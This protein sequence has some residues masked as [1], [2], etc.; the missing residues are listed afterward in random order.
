MA[1]TNCDE[2][3]NIIS[4]GIITWDND[5]A[6]EIARLSS[7]KKDMLMRSKKITWEEWVDEL[8]WLSI[9]ELEL[10]ASS[11]DIELRAIVQAKILTEDVRVADAYRELASQIKK[12]WWTI[13]S[14]VDLLEKLRNAPVTDLEEIAKQW[15]WEYAKEPVKAIK[16][17][18]EAIASTISANYSIRQYSDFTS[19]WLM[20]LKKELREWKI[21]QKEFDKW[22]TSLHKEA[23]EQI[24]K[25]ENPKNFAKLDS[26]WNFIKKVYWDE[27]LK[28]WEAWTQF[29]MARELLAD[30]AIDDSILEAFA[31]LWWKNLA[32][33]LT[34]DWI[35]KCWKDDLAVLLAKAY[36]NTKQLYTDWVLREVYRQKLVELAGWTK[37]T[38]ENI[39]KA[40]SILNTIQFAEQWATFSHIVL[41]DN[42][43]RSAQRLW[44]KIEDWTKFVYWIKKFCK[45]LSEKPE[46]LDKPIVINWVEMSAL[47]LVQVIYD[48][49]WDENILK[50]I[51]LWFFPD[52]AILSVATSRLL[53]G[54]KEAAEKILKLFSKAKQVAKV[55]STRDVAMKTICGTEVKENAPIGFFD[56]KTSL[57]N[58]DKL[59]RTRADFMDKLA[60]K[61][62]MK[63]PGGWVSV[64]QTTDNVERLEKSLADY[65]W[66]YIVVRDAQWRD[67]DVLSKAIDNVNKDLADDEKITLLFP[68]WWITS[69]FVME[70]WQLYFKTLDDDIFDSVSW[71]ISIQTLMESRPTREILATAYE[72][73]TWKNWDKL[74]YQA[75]YTRWWQSIDG[76]TLSDQQLE[77]FA[78]AKVWDDWELREWVI[79]L[80]H[81]TA[82][83]YFTKFDSGKASVE[84][85]WWA[86]FYST[87]NKLDARSNYEW[88]WPVLEWKIS[89]RADIL[90]WEWMSRNEAEII[91]R[92]ELEKEPAMLTVY[93]KMEN[94]A[95]VGKTI[96]FD[97]LDEDITYLQ[98]IIL[99]SARMEYPLTNRD[100]K[101]IMQIVYEA[102]DEWWI[103]IEVF[104]KRLGIVLWDLTDDEGNLAVNDVARLILKDLWYDWIIDPTVASKFKWMWLWD[105]TVHYIAFD[106]N[107]YKFIDNKLPTDNLDMRYQKSLRLYSTQTDIS[108][109]DAM[110][111]QMFTK[112]RT[113]KQIADWYWLDVRLVEWN[114][115]E[116]IKAYWAYW[117]WLIYF[118]DLVKES[119]A[120]HELF[121]AV[122][123][124]AWKEQ[125]D[126]ILSDAVKLFW[127]DRIEAEEKLADAFA[128]WFKTWKFSYWDTSKRW[129]K[130]L[131]KKVEQFFKT[132]AEWLWLLDNHRNEVKQMFDD[133]VNMRYLPDAWKDINATEA[134]IKYNDELNQAASKYFWEILWISAP[135]V[136]TPEYIDSVQQILSDMLWIDLKAFSEI[137]NKSALWKKINQQFSL[138]KITTGKYDKQLIDI[139]EVKNEIANYTEDE[140]EENIKND[141]WDLMITG[142]IKWNDNI[143]HIREA[144]LDYKTAPTAV[145]SLTAKWKIVSLANWWTAQT[146]TMQ[147]I[148]DMFTNWTF[149][150]KYK[151]MFFPNQT[152]TDKDL[153]KFANAIN[154]DIFDTLSIMFA[155]N[156]VSAWYSLPLINIKE[157]VYDYLHW[158]LNLN[159]K[160]VSSFLYKNWIPFTQDWLRWIVETLMPNE[161]KFNYEDS[162]FKW[163]FNQLEKWKVSAVVEVDNI[164]LWDSYSALAS[165]EWARAW[166]T[167]TNHEKDILTSILDKYNTAVTEWIKDWTLTFQKAQQL[168]QEA[169]YALDMF[170]QDFLLPRYW[171]FLT[172]TERQWLMWMK[173]SLPIWV[174]W[175]NIDKV[176]EELTSI[177]TNLIDKYD[178]ILNWAVKNNE[179]NMA[180]VKWMEWE[181]DDMKKRIDARRQQLIENWWIIKEVGWTYVVYDVKQALYD[182]INNLPDN[183][184]WLEWLKA[185][186][187]DWIESMSNK[188]AYAVLRYLEAAKWLNTTVNYATSIMYRLNP[189]LAKCNFFENYKAVNWIPRI[190]EWNI[191]NSNKFL[192]QFDNVSSFDNVAKKTIFSK[193]V[194]KFKAQGYLTSN[195]LSKIV[196]DWVDEVHSTIKL[197]WLNPEDTQKAIDNMKLVY[198]KAFTPYTYVRDI[199]K[200]WKL[201][202]WRTT[203][204]NVKARVEWVMKQQYEQAIDDLKAVWI[205]D[206]DNVQNSIYIQLNN[207]DRISLADAGKMNIDSWKKDIFNDE[208]VFVAWADEL[209]TFEWSPDNTNLLE[210]QKEY[211]NWIISQYDS[212]L[213]SL[214]SQTQFISDSE[215]KLHTAF[216]NDVRQT[217]RWY[218]LT[219]KIVDALD[220]VGWLNEEAARWI[221][222]YLIWWK[223]NMAFG[224]W[225][226]N[227]I[228]DRNKLVKEA[229]RNY[230]YMDISK[231]NKVVPNSKAEDLAL[232]LAKYFKSLER[233]LGSVD[234]LTW[235]TTKASLNRAFY[236]I[237]EVVMNVDTV[238]WIFWLLSWIE[239]N[240]LL[241]FFK[242]SKWELRKNSD[243]F[244]RQGKG[245]FNESLWWYR[246]YAEQI[247]WITQDEFNEIFATNFSEKEFSRVLQWLTGFSLV[248]SRWKK[249]MQILN[250]LNWSNFVFRALMSYPWQLLTIPQQT[251]AYFLKQMWFERSQW[252]ESLSEVDTVRQTTW[253]LDW[254]YN[255][256]FNIWKSSVS[257]D[258]VRLDSSFNR[259][260][261]PNT[262]EVYKAINV[263]S[264]DDYLNMYAK[265]NNYWASSISATDDVIRALDPYK[266]NANNF[267]DWIF[268]RNFKNI[269]FQKAIKWNDFLQFTSAKE[270][271]NFIDDTTVPADVK[272]KLMDRVAAYSWRNFRNILWL[273]FWWID[274]VVG[275]NWFWNIIYWI[276]QLF[277]FRWSWWQNIFK[278]TWAAMTTAMKMLSLSKW[279]VSREWKE[280]I[281]EYIAK[282]PEF[283]NFVSALFNDLKWTWK[284]QRF[285]DNGKFPE[286][287]DM[288]D[289]LDFIEYIT[290]T[291]N[292]TS[293]WY[294]WL[295]SYW[296][297]RPALEALW[298]AWSSNMN[299]TIYKDTF[300]VWAFFN[301]LWKNFW[302]QWKPYNWIAKFIWARVTNWPEW[303][304]DYLQN[305]RWKL[306]FGSL[307]YMVNEDMNWYGY[308]YEM[309]WQEWWIPSILMWE[310]KLGS[311]K[312]F[313]YELD[314][315]ETWETIK[316][317]FDRDNPWDTRKVYVWNL[318]KT[319]VNWSQLLSLPK[320]LLRLKRAPWYSTPSDLADTIQ[321][322]EA[323]KEFYSRWVVTPTTPEEA[324]K[325]FD[326][327]LANSQY[328][329]GSSSFT[330]SIMQFDA[331]WHMAWEK[332]TED[333]DDMELWLNRMKYL[334]N[335]HW[336]YEMDWWEKIV[337]PSWNMLMQEIQNKWYDSTYVTSLI[338]NYSKAWLNN[339]SSD[340]NYQ[341]YVKMLW[342]WQAHLLVEKQLDDI[343][344][345][346][347]VWQKWKDNKWTESEF[348]A[349]GNYNQMLLDLWSSV[350]E[351]DDITFFEKLQRLD[352]DDSTVAALAIIQSQAKWE[353]RKTLNKFF[354]VTEKD[355]W[356]QSVKLKYNYEKVLMQ[357]GAMA[358]AIDSWDVELALAEASTLVNMYS[359]SDPTGAITASIIDSVYNRVY[360]TDRFTPSQKQDIMI[361]LFHKNKDFIQKNPEE[362]REYLWDDYDVFADYMNQMLY[363]WDSMTISNL[364]SIQTGGNGSSWKSSAAWSFSSALK[365]LATSYG[366]SWWSSRWTGSVGSYKDWVPVVIKWA[367][368]VKDL[369][370]KGYTPSEVG[371]NLNPYKPHTDL[372]IKKDIKRKVKPKTTTAVSSSKQISKIEEKTQKAIE[373]E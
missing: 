152:L 235:C 62:K 120:P 34:I 194:N 77:Y 150:D 57:Y 267:I 98:D 115:I 173:Y 4:L 139:N 182:T 133:I 309:A 132:I 231:L 136:I 279:W 321:S 160:F 266:D 154:G 16:E 15:W 87:N 81:W 80:Y 148:K 350:L 151:T 353:D 288:Y 216:W 372:S 242:F 316:Q 162:L 365:K 299:P 140:L 206:L 193:I 268:A 202:D 3:S 285:Q 31:K 203:V 341:L 340:P 197:L 19:W 308:T 271:L 25:W 35:S 336:E 11:A 53:W 54:T 223:W 319:M 82:N 245:S 330:K 286:D 191:L 289:A 253:I 171:K 170:E 337:D 74:R 188:Q 362:L 199:P 52:W 10:K 124:M 129:Q 232:R 284:L 111:L 176:V 167:I 44:L 65:K 64:I 119:T 60:E 164:F 355:D 185:L 66:W 135:D 117:D 326:I 13:A 37:V 296:P 55:S 207:W 184:K 146:M 122:F 349:V 214:M 342:Q 189:E 210:K 313:V 329:P 157:F 17:M 96:I 49:T 250:F 306:S 277:N 314:N 147:E 344:A 234:W 217:M 69:S 118:S 367:N 335:E 187:K 278:Q 298:S 9:N 30:W 48:I 28:A 172:R 84:W 178:R 21:T 123:D 346:L 276:T 227:Q 303:A 249:W 47:D 177:R 159:N 208:S 247:S 354:D 33:D 110:K 261:L 93:V 105:W 86:W 228:L 6:N 293:Q 248:G 359:N 114:M 168:K 327:M 368:L 371:I 102:L 263:D 145:D 106:E 161:F 363:Q 236:H 91:A 339:H 183:I 369:W 138:E 230:Y 370:L 317:A 259:Y 221:K 213:S 23:M 131:F 280:I 108:P 204:R 181:T 209:K 320:N 45:E 127:Y 352:E 229:Y 67:N 89:R 20:H 143:E 356:T 233:L 262:N 256:L 192:S 225:K 238:K 79:E 272:T 347:N 107:Q 78:W 128:E 360:D 36:T 196:T 295:Q 201:I 244:I 39:S 312:N 73:T 76:N 290:E 174:A 282:T 311:D 137:E 103:E 287:D 179:V 258:D 246:D 254:A 265:I 260:W 257:P 112:D 68:R 1:V 237:W 348:K 345:A 226:P 109:D 322:T 343:V 75:S 121:H 270:F 220:S 324:K 95:I 315:T 305:E 212:A 294:Q 190:L 38:K 357:V 169:W 58:K 144:Y 5:L 325:F 32:W 71:T 14:W 72:A 8:T 186:W 125:K 333:D 156:L 141:L 155:D 175:Q 274:R 101:E 153:T 304:N 165:I 364:E 275:W 297:M 149:N 100:E 2:L 252:I 292:M 50:L 291:L 251:L 41:A 104:K 332:W 358:K 63:V 46:I 70:E 113:W 130:T 373:T 281:A 307:R 211:R 338:Y 243:V 302:R 241:K 205:W 219:N 94:P 18:R 51:K 24:A 59:N 255:E 116:W 97:E 195:D 240:Q 180:I 331:Y 283:S 22:I 323:W 26:E 40:T 215:K 29:I 328:R 300:W 222:D 318:W 310:S 269:A 134:M 56:Y 61:N 7:I 239:Q 85:D 166:E 366:W 90:E 99:D 88:W 142:V 158:K 12:T 163:R 273:G 200:W 301:A 126:K 361:A 42:A 198:M 92:Q 27:P 218:T 224:A 43:K 83:W 264:T 334:T 351:W